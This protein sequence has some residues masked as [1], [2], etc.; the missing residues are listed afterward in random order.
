MNKQ[1]G[2][3]LAGSVQFDV[4]GGQGERFFNECAQNSI[5]V[6]SIHAT[7]LGFCASV[8]LREYRK[9]HHIARKHRCKLKISQK[10]G[11][12]FALWIYR[13]RWGILLGAAL[14][15]VVS[16]V[17]SRMIWSV[18][19]YDFTP[20]EQAMV[21]SQLYVKE[22]CEGR[23]VSKDDLAQAQYALFLENKEYAW[24]KLNFIHG[25][26]IVEKTTAEPPPLLASQEVTN[27]VAACDGWIQ[28]IEVSGG[29]LQ[30]TEGQFV[31]KG[32]VLVS[33]VYQGLR[34]GVISQHAEAKVYAMVEPVYEVRQ[35]LESEA[36]VPSGEYKSYYTLHFM[37]L[38][39][40]LFYQV[41][42]QS[43]ATQTVLKYPFRFFGFPLPL[44]I[45][46]LQVRSTQNI[47]VQRSEKE[48]AEVARVR[49]YDAMQ[50]D[51]PGIVLLEEKETI[52]ME[53]NT[54]VL[55]LEAK[56]FADIA[57]MAPFSAQ[58]E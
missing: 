47:T 10:R 43:S 38:K 35:P 14:A 48:A 51:L 57:R 28:R 18:R 16:C 30:H 9:L 8:P 13:K 15:V 21:R 49:V 44:T 32:D 37:K 23:I 52:V 29:L 27:V 54:L 45:E 20:K 11:L 25:R 7:A 12:Y 26:L 39:L 31:A 55:R 19:F 6:Q 24:I 17:F 34:E 42:A 5:P 2:A 3:Y 4:L 1:W 50:A 56:A 22:I 46:E 58:S 36:S 53:E 33:G 41:K 40:P